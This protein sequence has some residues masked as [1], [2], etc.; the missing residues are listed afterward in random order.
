[1]FIKGTTFPAICFTNRT[2]KGIPVAIKEL[3]S[4][5]E[6]H[7]KNIRDEISTQCQI[8]NRFIIK[9]YGCCFNDENSLFIVMELADCSLTT[10]LKKERILY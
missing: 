7:L 8:D 9:V 5:D 1:M 2:Y 4:I 6:Y 10:Y 3:K